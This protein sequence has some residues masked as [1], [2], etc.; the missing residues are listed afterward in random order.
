VAVDAARCTGCGVCAVACPQG[1]I[2]LEPVPEATPLR[3]EK[4]LG[5]IRL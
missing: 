1:A 5:E 3:V 4:W 2:R